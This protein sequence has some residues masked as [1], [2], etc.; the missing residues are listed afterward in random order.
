MLSYSAAV[1]ACE[2][3]GEFRPGLATIYGDAYEFT[4]MMTQ[5]PELCKVAE[6]MIHKQTGAGSAASRR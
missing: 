1:T 5:N 2:R 4:L 3:G 6:E